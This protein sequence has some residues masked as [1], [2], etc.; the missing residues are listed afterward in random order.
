MSW[1]VTDT[2]ITAVDWRRFPEEKPEKDGDYL[3]YTVGDYMTVT[4]WSNKHGLFN[5]WDHQSKTAISP[6]RGVLWW[7]ECPVPREE[8]T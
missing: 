2:M 5:T 3:V 1:A 8:K 7:A 4:H 6:I